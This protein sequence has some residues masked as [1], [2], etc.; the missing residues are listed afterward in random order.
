MQHLIQQFFC[1][2]VKFKF[3]GDPAVFKPI[4]LI[5]HRYCPDLQ[6]YVTGEY[7]EQMEEI[8]WIVKLD[9]ESVKGMFDPVI[10]RVIKLIGDQLSE[11]S[12]RC[13]AMFLVGGFSESPYLLNRVRE[14]FKDQVPIIAVPALPI[15][16]VVRGAVTY[17]LNAEIVHERVLKWTYGIEVCRSWVRAICSIRVIMNENFIYPLCNI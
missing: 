13:S 14:T 7:K 2:M 5:L 16:A 17:G 3:K 4:R 6:Q 10:D 1:N 12:N 9:F 11:A 8:G 15:A